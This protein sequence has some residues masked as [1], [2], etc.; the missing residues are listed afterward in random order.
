VHKLV[1]TL[2]AFTFSLAAS[3]AD[4]YVIGSAEGSLFKLEVYKTGLMSGKSHIFHF[5]Q[6]S[7]ELTY[8]KAEP[9]NSTIQFFV[10]SA[11]AVCKDDW[12]KPKQLKDI[13][14]YALEDMLEA[15]VH[16]KIVFESESV[17]P[18]ADGGFTVVGKLAIR[19]RAVPSTVTVKL[20]PAGESL[21]FSG[22]AV[23]SLKDYGIKPKKAA[24]GTI[25]TKPE[26]DVTFSILASGS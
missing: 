11:S 15:K 3:A 18:A 5:T 19:G 6:F 4:R 8:D 20:E 7:G 9:K 17:S 1:A 22:A 24:L 10:D 2:A 21:K 14:K 13:E 25:G 12:V 16:P 26:M 23:V